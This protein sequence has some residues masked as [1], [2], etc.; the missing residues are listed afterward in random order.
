MFVTGTVTFFQNA[1]SDSIMEGFKNFIPPMCTV[2]RDG[3]ENLI[4][5][6][7]LVTGDLIIVIV[8]E[9]IPADIRIIMS[10]EMKVDNS[11][12]TGESDPLLRKIECTDPEKILETSNVAFFGTL[13]NNGKGKGIVFNIGDDT[14]I[15]QIAGLADEAEAGKTPLRKEL[16]RFIKMITII[17]LIMGIIFFCSGFLLKYNLI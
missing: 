1:K 7:K 5:A 6:E 12:L 3:K 15:G 9:R 8:G 4:P 13:C 11:S 16:D 14:I 10:N 17:A 2:L